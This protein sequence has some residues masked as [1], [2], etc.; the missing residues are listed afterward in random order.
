M[1]WPL[2]SKNPYA[3][4]PTCPGRLSR[5]PRLGRR[6][7]QSILGG[8]V[9]RLALKCCRLCT[10][11]QPVPTFPLR[12]RNRP[13]ASA[14]R[15]YKLVSRTWRRRVLGRR[16]TAAFWVVYAAVVLTYTGAVRPNLAQFWAGVFLG[17]TLGLWYALPDI[18]RPPY[19]ANW[20]R[21]AVGERSTARNLKALEKRGWVVRHDVATPH[22]GNRDHIVAGPALYLIDSKN[23]NDSA[24]K[25]EGLALRIT[26]LDDPDDQYVLDAL[27]P[28]MQRAARSLERELRAATGIGAAVYPIVA[29]WGR[30]EARAT[31]AGDV[32]V[33]R[34][35]TLADWIDRRPL[36]I[37]D[38]AKRARVQAWVRD[39]PSR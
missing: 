37:L 36:D 9:R 20:Q 3:A 2:L 28:A 7:R 1:A 27:V 11:V 25:V 5:D 24:A 35:D 34:A 22:R 29:I 10:E 12:S 15:H 38:P 21:G 17:G 6:R 33:V 19:I 14:E 8:R 4:L 31:Y 32:A 30:F 16:V 13:G 23:F 18:L 39:L 26:R